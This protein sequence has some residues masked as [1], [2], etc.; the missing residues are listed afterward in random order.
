M[1]PRGLTDDALYRSCR[2][3][4]FAGK[5]LCCGG[6][7]HDWDEEPRAVAEGVLMC[8]RC[9]VNKHYEPPEILAAMLK[10]LVS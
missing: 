3:C 9:F 10:A 7:L 4:W 2:P 6:G 1:N 5:C 8:G